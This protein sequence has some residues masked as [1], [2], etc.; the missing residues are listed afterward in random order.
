MVSDKNFDSEDG[1]FKI[2]VKDGTLNMKPE[3]P[4]ELSLLHLIRGTLAQ[5]P[6]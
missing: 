4:E 2:Q 1:G 5:N 6:L 3:I